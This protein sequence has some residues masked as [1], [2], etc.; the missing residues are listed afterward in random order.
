[1]PQTRLRRMTVAPALACA[2]VL[3]AC[4]APPA[5]GPAK[6]IASGPTPALLPLDDLLDAPPAQASG[7]AAAALSARGTALRAEV[8]GTP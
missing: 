6:P 7:E 3:S 8:L 4:T 1:M 5:L 2:L